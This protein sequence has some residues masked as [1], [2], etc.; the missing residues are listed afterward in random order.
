MNYFYFLAFLLVD[1]NF[2]ILP[3]LIIFWV[4]TDS[5]VYNVN[6]LVFDH[7]IWK[8]GVRFYQ[9]ESETK[10]VN[11]Y[12]KMPNYQL[13]F[14]PSAHSSHCHILSAKYNYST[15]IQT[16]LIILT[17]W[18][19]YKSFNSSSFEKYQQFFMINIHEI[20]PCK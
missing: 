19:D 18:V 7:L 1:V 17:E 3:N 14:I 6:P 12:S 2:S 8:V 20:H 5:K 16:K 4:L 9:I 13:S 15:A 11:K 10:F